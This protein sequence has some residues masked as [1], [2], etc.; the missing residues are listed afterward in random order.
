M[1]INMLHIHC[2]SGTVCL[3]SCTYLSPLTFSGSMIY[4]CCWVYFTQRLLCP[5]SLSFLIC[6]DFA[7]SFKD[8]LCL[9]TQ[10]CKE[11][12]LSQVSVGDLNKKNLQNLYKWGK[13][14]KTNSLKLPHRGWPANSVHCCVFKYSVSLYLNIHSLCSLSRVVLRCVCSLIKDWNSTGVN[15]A[16]DTQY[17]FELCGVWM[18]IVGTLGQSEARMPL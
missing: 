1:F 10:L 17:G 4:T 18:C 3:S 12:A 15:K 6:R 8:T 2:P 5:T 14:G 16:V 11:M 7:S 13:T 9:N